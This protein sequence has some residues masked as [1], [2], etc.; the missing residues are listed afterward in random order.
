METKITEEGYLEKGL[1]QPVLLNIHQ[2]VSARLGLQGRVDEIQITSTEDRSVNRPFET[3]NIG[4]EAFQAGFSKG[5]FHVRVFLKSDY[6]V[7]EIRDARIVE[8]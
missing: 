1:S 8:D 4:Y 3:F 7:E 6:S 2:A 5:R